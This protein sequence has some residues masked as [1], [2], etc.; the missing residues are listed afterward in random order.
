MSKIGK[1]IIQIPKGVEIHQKDGQVLVK[2]PKGELKMN[3]PSSILVS[4][5]AGIVTLKPNADQN[6]TKAERNSPWGLSRALIQNMITGVTEGFE[7]TLEFE[8]VGYKANIKG[9]DLELNLGF[10]HSITIKAPA[11]ITIKAEKNVIKISG[12]DKELIGHVAAEIRSKREPEPYKGSGIRY[13][14]E[15]IKKKAGK[16]AATTA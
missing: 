12:I 1:K 3:L 2:G 6:R 4:I 14:G 11:G 15:I 13:K 7:K 5:D 10:S 8:G 9:N 16:K